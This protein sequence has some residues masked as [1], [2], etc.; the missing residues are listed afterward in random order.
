MLHEYEIKELQRI[1]TELEA[2]E[3]LSSAHSEQATKE[4]E[5]WMKRHKQITDLGRRAEYIA[6]LT[7]PLDIYMLLGKIETRKG[8]LFNLGLTEVD[9][10][11]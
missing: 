6:L 4:H 8:V 3:P 1:L 11:P 10:E 5:E 2:L 7:V 9:N